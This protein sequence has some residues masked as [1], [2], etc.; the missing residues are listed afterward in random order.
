MTWTYDYDSKKMIVELTYSGDTSARDLKDSTSELIAFGEKKGVS[1]V[2]IDTTDMKYRSSLVDIY[3]LP[4]KQYVNENANRLGRTALI[5][6]TCTKSREAAK[7]YET[8]CRNR[9]W[10]VR[11]FPTRMEAMDW[12]MGPDTP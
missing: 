4:A 2:L 5:L 10:M 1:L 8:V 9:G 3:D 7:F 12:L 6:P 11:A